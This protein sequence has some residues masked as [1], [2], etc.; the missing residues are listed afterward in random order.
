MCG[1]CGQC[2]KGVEAT[3]LEEFIVQLKGHLRGLMAEPKAEGVHVCSDGEGLSVSLPLGAVDI[4]GDFDL[5]A[6][7]ARRAGMPLSEFVVHAAAEWA[8]L[9]LRAYEQAHQDIAAKIKACGV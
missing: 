5:I 1:Q 4:S 3:P 2:S 9:Y 7:A 8:D 6:E